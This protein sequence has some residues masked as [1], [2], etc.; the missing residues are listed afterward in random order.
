MK[1]TI[2]RHLKFLAIFIVILTLIN[3]TMTSNVSNL[4]DLGRCSIINQNRLKEEIREDYTRKI[5]FFVFVTYF[6]TNFF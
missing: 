2:P 1:F 4:K 5:I 6:Y 3:I